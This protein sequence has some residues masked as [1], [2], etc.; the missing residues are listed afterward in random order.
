MKLPFLNKPVGKKYQ[1][2]REAIADG[3][4]GENRGCQFGIPNWFI[5]ARELK[6]FYK[7]TQPPQI[8]RDPAEHIAIT[9]AY[10]TIVTRC[11]QVEKFNEF[12][13][14]NQ[15]ENPWD[16]EANSYYLDLMTVN[17]FVLALIL[18]ELAQDTILGF[19]SAIIPLAVRIG[20]LGRNPNIA[21]RQQ[22]INRDIRTATKRNDPIRAPVITKWD[23]DQMPNTPAE[24]YRG[25]L[26][27]WTLLGC[28]LVVILSVPKGG[29]KES[30][31]AEMLMIS[32]SH[33][34]SVSSG[35]AAAIT[36]SC[37]C[38]WVSV[39]EK[40]EQQL[41]LVYDP[42]CLKGRKGRWRKRNDYCPVCNKGLLIQ[43][44]PWTNA[45]VDTMLK[46][47]GKLARSPRRTLATAL[48]HWEL[49]YP[50]GLGKYFNS[51]F[52][53]SEKSNMFD[54]YASDYRMFRI[55]QLVPVLGCLH[56]VED[57]EEILVSSDFKNCPKADIPIIEQELA[58]A[59]VQGQL[60]ERDQEL[61]M[62]RMLVGMRK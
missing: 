52:R 4:D 11:Y 31:E 34:K 42:S 6:L 40:R 5:P 57:K 26:L 8:N 13:R 9:F 32:T 51:I 28:R 25:S 36:V 19:S 41:E 48:R 47:A 18:E 46:S 15:L 22:Q 7:E 17:D 27:L 21:L 59:E 30:T 62:L 2:R 12:C 1:A 39:P 24:P 20:F 56:R 44:F 54:T 33:D 58:A 16:A 50:T 61:A 49:S 35:N 55:E 43:P 14:N 60:D 37:N 3:F 29:L 45:F 53:W 23:F 38:F 10:A